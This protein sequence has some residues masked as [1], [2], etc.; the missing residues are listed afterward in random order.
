MIFQSIFQNAAHIISPFQKHGK[1]EQLYFQCQQVVIVSTCP[2]LQT[3]IYR[4]ERL[5]D[6]AFGEL[7]DYFQNANNPYE[8]NRVEYLPPKN[9]R[10]DQT[11]GRFPEQCQFWEK[12]RD[13]RHVFSIRLPENYQEISFLATNNDRI[14]SSETCDDYRRKRQA[15][16]EQAHACPAQQTEQVKRIASDGIR[17]FRNQRGR[18]LSGYVLSAPN[19]AYGRDSNEYPTPAKH[20]GIHNMSPGQ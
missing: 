5:Y 7:P 12:T 11:A 15:F 3:L 4:N 10:V 16:S 20:H 2:A 8:K 1:L 19:P 6:T 17:P 9:T 18:F 14:K 13:I